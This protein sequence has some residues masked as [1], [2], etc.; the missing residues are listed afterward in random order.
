MRLIDAE[1]I[2]DYWVE[3]E[4]TKEEFIK[5]YM[6]KDADYN[7][8]S[9]FFDKVLQAFKNVVAT[10]PTIEAEP[11]VRCAECKYNIVNGGNCDSTLVTKATDFSQFW[12]KY[13][14]HGIKMDEEQG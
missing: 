9:D 3:S 5:E 4:G 7:D 11:V 12:L 8:Y 10:S 13:C 6:P 2:T 1:D 14:S